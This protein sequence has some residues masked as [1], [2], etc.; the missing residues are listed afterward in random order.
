[1]LPLCVADLAL[2]LVLMLCVFSG[3]GR[4]RELPSFPTRRSSDLH[5]GDYQLGLW[6]FASLGVLA[7]LGLYGVKQ[8]WRTTWGSAAVTD[9][10][11]D[12]KSTRLNSSHV[13][14]SYAVF[15]LKKKNSNTRCICIPLDASV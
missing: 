13:K 15:C 2:C 11:V 8:R 6:L 1:L 10:R 9:A 14:I 3:S 7:W 12:R 4:H 5:S